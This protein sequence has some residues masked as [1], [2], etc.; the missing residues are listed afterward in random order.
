M[1]FVD[2]NKT[3]F[4][5]VFLLYG[6]PM[7]LDVCW[8]L[9]W[10]GHTC[11]RG[12]GLNV[13]LFFYWASWHS[14]CYNV[15]K[16]K[17]TALFCQV[18][19]VYVASRVDFKYCPIKKIYIFLEM[20]QYNW[21]SQ[22]W[23]MAQRD[24][25]H[26][27]VWFRRWTPYKDGV[28]LIP[29]IHRQ[30]ARLTFPSHSIRSLGDSPPVRPPVRPSR[31]FLNRNHAITKSSLTW[32]VSSPPP[33]PAHTAT[34]RQINECRSIRE[35]TSRVR[36]EASGSAV[37]QPTASRPNCTVLFFFLHSFTSSWQVCVYVFFLCRVWKE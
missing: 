28:R 34:R 30:A 36:R 15:N 33:S 14:M 27:G 32:A 7:K 29:S 22:K 11:K 18:L 4:M 25:S 8:C 37:T 35:K 21:A 19:R 23:P 10:P 2:W 31:G 20:F 24:A 6:C 12:L 13:C 17:C 1:H 5:I 9:H 3:C 16:P 26:D